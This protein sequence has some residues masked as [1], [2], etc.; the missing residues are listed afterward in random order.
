MPDSRL[1]NPLSRR[2]L[3]FLLLA[4]LALNLALLA[5]ATL[6]LGSAPP[7]SPGGASDA[8]LQPRPAPTFR[9]PD[10]ADQTV[11]LLALRGQPVVLHF[12]TTWCAICKEEMPDLQAAYDAF[13]G[14]GLVLLAI[15]VKESQELIHPY[16]QE[17]RLDFP[18]LVDRKG[19]VGRLY[20]VSAFPVTYLIDRDGQISQVHAGR[21]TRAQFDDLFGVLLARGTATPSPTPTLGPDMLEGCVT[22]PQLSLRSGPTTQYELALSVKLRQGDCLRFDGRTTDGAWLRLAP[23]HP[24]KNGGRLWALSRQVEIKGEVEALPVVR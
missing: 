12:W 24:G 13:K 5:C 21:L 6:T 22:A 11:D 4:L 1:S 8:L 19:Q 7:A 18:V 9:L 15:N 10:L 20:Q 23:D 16:L 17:N 14:Q 2:R 3:L